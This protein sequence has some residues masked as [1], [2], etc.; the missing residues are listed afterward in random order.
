MSELY[1]SGDEVKVKAR[2]KKLIS[3]AERDLNRIR[4]AMSNVDTRWFVQSLIN[5]SGMNAD[6]FFAAGMPDVTHYNLGARDLGF[7]AHKQVMEACP[8]LLA[9]A[10]KE[11]NQP[12]SKEDDSE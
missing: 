3:A 8:E 12:Q 1:D 5:K 2:A 6:S 10:Q 9:L 4:R 11:M 7:W